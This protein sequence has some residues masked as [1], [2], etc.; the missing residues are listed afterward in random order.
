[1]LG[2]D[3]YDNC[4]RSNEEWRKD[5]VRLARAKAKC[6]RLAREWAEVAELL[7]KAAEYIHLRVDIYQQYQKAVWNAHFYANVT[8]TYLGNLAAFGEDE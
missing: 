6:E 4:R 1:M 5:P 7:G 8:D 2:Y 3:E